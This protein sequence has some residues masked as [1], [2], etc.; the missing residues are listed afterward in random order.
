MTQVRITESDISVVIDL[1]GH[2]GFNPGNDI[3]CASISTLSYTLINYLQL[4]KQENRLSELSINDESG[5]HHIEAKTKRG[6]EAELQHA[7]GFFKI[8]LAMISE[9][10]PSYLRVDSIGRCN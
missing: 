5:H 3:V 8:G 9:H 6:F 2:A 4:M 7:I 10:Y 1:K